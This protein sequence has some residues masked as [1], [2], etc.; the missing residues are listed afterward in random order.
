MLKNELAKIEAVQSIAGT[1]HNL[2]YGFQ[3][4]SIEIDGIKH[5][6]H[7][8]FVGDQYLSTVGCQIV[9]GRDF[10][11]N[12]EN[13]A[14]ESILVNEHFVALFYVDVEFT[15]EQLESFARQQ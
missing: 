10:L 1:I 11:I 12:S 6:S 13:D 14:A 9:E 8:L 4:A 2:G 5:N 3:E 7:Q 15:F